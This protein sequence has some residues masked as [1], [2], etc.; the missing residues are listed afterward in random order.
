M[1]D[2]C[3]EFGR[4]LYKKQGAMYLYSEHD[5]TAIPGYHELWRRWPWL[6]EERAYRVLTC[7][8]CPPPTFWAVKMTTIIYHLND[9]HRWTRP[10]IAEWLA[11]IEPPEPLM[12]EDKRVQAP[13]QMENAVAV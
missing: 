4:A 9:R 7:P 11:T 5:A 13:E 1:L 3:G 6:G 2:G 10:Q 8:A 12:L